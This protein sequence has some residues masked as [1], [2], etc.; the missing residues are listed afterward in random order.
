[1]ARAGVA[2]AGGELVAHARGRKPDALRNAR[3]DARQ[4]ARQAEMLDRVRGDAGLFQQRRDGGRDDLEIALVADPALLPDV[5]ELA[6]VAAMMIDEIHRR[7]MLRDERG[8]AVAG[9]E[10]H[11]GAAVAAR[12]L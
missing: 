4:R 1:M 3:G 6:A 9:A 12:K 11:G 5:V 2:A 7:G 8:N 10:Q